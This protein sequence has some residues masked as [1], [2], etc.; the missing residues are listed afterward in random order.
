MS[1]LKQPYLPFQF[2]L[3][4]NSAAVAA[5]I[6][7]PVSLSILPFLMNKIL[8]YVYST[9]GTYFKSNLPFS[10]Q[11]RSESQRLTRLVRYLISNKIHLPFTW[12]L[13]VTCHMGKP[14]RLLTSQTYQ[15]IFYDNVTPTTSA[16]SQS[17]LHRVLLASWHGWRA[18]PWRGWKPHCSSSGLTVT[19]LSTT[20]DCPLS[21][22]FSFLK[23]GTTHPNLPPYINFLHSPHNVAEPRKPYSIQNLK[24]LRAHLVLRGVPLLWSSLTAS[25][26]FALELRAPSFFWMCVLLFIYTQWNY[27]SVRKKLKGDD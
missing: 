12:Y 11:M 23:M 24:V 5:Q 3:Q 2:S 27:R 17:Y 20:S 8:W 1:L 18:G 22:Y 13:L 26:T 6:H 16:L 25:A 19:L 14:T 21:P 4:H 7:L 15:I 10:S 9:Q